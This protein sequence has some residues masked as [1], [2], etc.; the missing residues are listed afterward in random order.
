LYK[1]DGKN[2]GSGE[3]QI[4]YH[5]TNNVFKNNIVYAGAQALAIHNFTTSVAN[6]ADVD[7]NLYFSPGGATGTTFVWNNK[8]Y[9]TFTAY[10]SGSGKDG[11]GGFSDPQ[12]LN[13]TTPD[14]RVRSTSPAVNAGI[15]L[16]SV[17]VG[18]LD[19]AGNA[20]V[21]GSNIDIGGYEQ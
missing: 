16:G 17:V 19:F 2:T 20:R 15:N 18:T 7:Y 6:P 11:N 4:Q 12:F 9:G 10:Q 3:F 8:T 21:Q 1:N 5:A 13:G 14:L